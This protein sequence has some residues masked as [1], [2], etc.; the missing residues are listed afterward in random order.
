MT[1][2]VKLTKMLLVA[3]SKVKSANAVPETEAIVTVVWLLAGLTGVDCMHSTVVPLAHD[4]VLQST[5]AI[6]A[7][8]VG[9]RDAKL[10]PLIVALAPPLVGV[11]PLPAR[12]NDTTG[13]IARWLDT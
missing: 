10:R 3:P 8:V 9:S 2:L 4:V 7:V 11:L 13:A 1:K 12:L 6:A 5:S